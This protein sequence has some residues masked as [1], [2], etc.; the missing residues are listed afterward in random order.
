M[1]QILKLFKFQLDNKY[2]LFKSRDVKAFFISLFKSICLIGAITLVLYLILNKI[3]TLLF[4]TINQNAIS[5]VLLVTQAISFAFAIASTINTLYMSKDNELLMVLPVTF[6]QLFVSKIMV[7]YVSELIFNTL[8]MLPVFLCLGWLG[9]LSIVY[10]A[11]LIFIIPLLPLLP[12]ALASILSIPIMFV[13]KFFKRH[14]VLSIVSILLVVATV[15]VLY[16][17]FVTKL[18]SVINIAE[19]QVATG[20][21]INNWL[22]STGSKIIVYYQI[23][24][25]MLNFKYFYFPLAFLGGSVL[26]V[27]M[28]FALIKP[29]YYKIS[30]INL[31][32]TSVVRT[33]HRPF[34]HRGV[35]AELFINEV[36]M[37]FRSPGYI[38]QF[39]LFPLFM[40]LIVFTYDKLLINIAVNQAG[41]NM[42]FGS[43]VLVLGIIALMSNTISS[44]AISKEGGTFYIAKTTPINYR[45]QALAKLSFNA[46]FT[47]GAI[48]VTTIVTIIATDLNVWIALLSSLVVTI[49]ALG[50]ICH[51]FDL[52]LQKPVLDWY[53]NSE[54]STIGKNTTKSMIYALALPVLLCLIITLFGLKGIFIAL[55]ISVI[56]LVGR[57]HLLNIRLDYYYT[58]MEI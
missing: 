15:F 45:V 2:N 18:S 24:L 51:S 10:F 49:L 37:V 56:Y 58:R 48:L 46:V 13:L 33:K 11:S 26:L 28:C 38:F 20:L 8:Y 3:F 9:R 30:T 14:N 50:H 53:D 31:E 5:V 57:I 25:A 35:F 44:I 32:T 39:F 1:S 42:I 7:L 22:V 27:V 16:M 47:V 21:K 4:I 41:Q 52:D 36:R 17:S 34:K 54:I 40:P 19:K 12:I 29:F 6:N 23:A 55:A 43:H